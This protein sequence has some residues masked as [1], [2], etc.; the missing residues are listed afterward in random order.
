M[1]TISYWQIDYGI[2]ILQNAN[3]FEKQ[4]MMLLQCIYKNEKN[5]LHSFDNDQT[6]IGFVSLSI[7]FRCHSSTHDCYWS[8]H[9]TTFFMDNAFNEKY[10]PQWSIRTY[11][12]VRI[13]H[14]LKEIILFDGCDSKYVLM[15]TSTSNLIRIHFLFGQSIV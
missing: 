11:C 13:Y 2:S 12:S 9:Q 15:C 3:G 4:W 6:Y 7:I 1:H 14:S 8:N 10:I 5:S